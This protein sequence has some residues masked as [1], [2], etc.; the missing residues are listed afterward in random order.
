[1]NDQVTAGAAMLATMAA[2]RAV[3]WQGT[4]ASWR[5]IVDLHSEIADTPQ[6]GI[7]TVQKPSGTETTHGDMIE[8]RRLQ[9]DTRK[10]L[11]SKVLP[12]VYGDRLTAARRVA[13]L[14]SAGADRL[15]EKGQ[16]GD[17]RH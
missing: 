2:D 1:M 16:S 13:F 14:L 9:V 8:Y 3:R 10:W 5:E 11:L 12:K 4:A 7:K 15:D 17:T 6:I